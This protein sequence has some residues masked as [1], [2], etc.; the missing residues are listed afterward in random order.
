MKS[1]R[2]PPHGRPG[3]DAGGAVTGTEPDVNR[4]MNLGKFKQAVELAKEQHKRLNTPESQRLLV[5]AYA[6][7]IGEFQK[8]GMAEEAQTLLT[9]VQQRFPS[10]R[11]QLGELEIRAAATGGRLQDLL[12]PLASEQT[13]PQVRASIEAALA[14][15]ITD[16]P[17][18]AAC[19]VLPQDHPL[20]LGAAAVWRAFLA[21]TSGPVTDAEISLPEISHRSSLAAWK[22]LIRA[23]A[24]FYREDDS[25]CLRALDAIPAESAIAQVGAAMKKL[26]AAYK[27]YDLTRLQNCMRDA[28]RTCS[29]SRP[30]LLDR[31]RQHISIGCFLNDVPPNAVAAAIGP[32]LKDAYFWRLLARATESEGAAAGAAMYWERFL[33][34][35][36]HE[37]MFAPNSMEA[38]TIWL[39]IAKVLARMTLAELDEARERWGGGHMIGGY[40][41]NQPQEIAAL[42]PA[43]DDRL[44]DSVLGPGKAFHHAAVIRPDADTFQRWWAWADQVDLPVKQKEDVALQWCRSRPGDAQPLLHLS[45]LA[46]KRNALSLA[47]KRLGEAEAIDPLNQ[48]VRQA[49]VR[50]TLSIA[51]RHFAD[52]KAHL[53]END[54]AELQALPGMAEGDRAAALESMR[55]TWRALR[56]DHAAQDASFQSVVERLGPIAAPVL[57]ATIRIAA[58]LDDQTPPTNM[59]LFV[60]AAPLEMALASARLIRLGTDLGLTLWQPKA[61]A[62]AIDEVLRQRPNPLSDSDLLALGRGAL[63][64][65]HMETAYLASAAGLTKH[66]SPA[67]TARFLLLRAQSLDESWHRPRTTQC[68]RAA[69]QMA[70]AA[71]DEEL[72]NDVFAVID[73]DS[74]TRR[75]IASARNGQSMPEDVLRQVLESERNAASYPRSNVDV[76]SFVVDAA[77]PDWSKRFG[78]DDF[79]SDW[80]EDDEDEDDW[81]DD[82]DTEPTLFGPDPEKVNQLNRLVESNQLQPEDLLANPQQA[83]ESM[84]KSMGMKLGQREL[85]EMIEGLAALIGGTG[86]DPEGNPFGGPGKKRRKRRR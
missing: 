32:T 51:W 44:A 80:D 12:R 36:V 8:K 40:Y 14:R 2:I 9:L 79:D 60:E 73:R 25:G 26:E 66:N 62:P 55:G 76:D 16:L 20:R 61:W 27:S 69:L 1:E 30:E 53:V 86:S 75:V 78:E 52:R 84:A 33:Q 68:L 59:Q 17:A 83:I 19:A 74:F 72:T 4:L 15:H 64:M 24:A 35:G 85:R 67:T 37:R 38:A 11:H 23:I 10:E 5:Q 71:H 48:Q 28:V 29:Q 21:V 49:R 34:H 46:E 63:N 57:Y 50:L 82:E 58:R 56:G 65:S 47:L 54:L 39:H 42:R 45:S 6:A 7:R 31:L 41:A 3:P 43:S 22:M 81:D 18:L 70:R 13:S 77:E